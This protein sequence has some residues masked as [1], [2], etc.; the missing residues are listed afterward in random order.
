MRR[1]SALIFL[2]FLLLILVPA[3]TA[4]PKSYGTELPFVLGMGA[5][6][7]GMG[8]AYTSVL[9]DP[10]VQFFNPAS[11]SEA[12]WKQFEFFRTVLFDSK[13]VYHTLSYSHPTTSYGTLGIS[14]LRMDIGGIE[15]RDINNQL[16]SDDMKNSQTRVLLGY[17][18]R[19]HSTISAGLNLKIDYQSF[20]G[21]N[22][23]GLG[24]D[25][26]FLSMQKLNSI[27]YLKELREALA[28]QNL[29]EPSIKLDQESVPD[30]M[31]LVFG[32]SALSEYKD[33]TF[34]TSIDLVNP[35][36]SPFTFRFGQ[37]V[38]VLKHF[39]LRIGVDDVTPMYGF[40]V[41]YN[42]F[43]LDY[44]YRSEDLGSNHRVS[45]SIAFG[46]SIDEQ[47]ENERK[48]L[49]KRIEDEISMKMEKIEQE[50]LKNTFR[51][52]DS[53]FAI[54]IFEEAIGYYE[55]TL[56]S[57]PDNQSTLSRI[58]T[59][60]YQMNIKM[61]KNSI[62]KEDFLT[63]MV[64]LRQALIYMPDDSTSTSLIN[65]CEQKLSDLRDRTALIN[66]MLKNSIDKYAEKHYLEA[67]LGFEEI[68]NIDPSHT[69]AN[70]YKQKTLLTIENIKQQKITLA[71][72]LAEKKDYDG[73]IN[74]MEDA[75]YYAKD[76]P[77]IIAEI[78]SLKRKKQAEFTS[79]AKLDSG[80]RIPKQ[81]TP[82]KEVRVDKS[83]LD[84]LYR[85][86]MRHFESGN[87][88]DA[89]QAFQKL[90]TLDPQ[91]HHVSKLLTKA[92]LL[93]GMRLY[94][95][96]EYEEAVNIWEKSLK[97]DP[98]NLKAKRYLIKTREEMEKLGGVSNG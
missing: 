58:E 5:R 76:D 28:I 33:L 85:V 30:P 50:Q 19:L 90:W 21:V 92:Y 87:F 72:T 14:I 6:S 69:L 39:A 34:T 38:Q 41:S 62:Q 74:A 54:E 88:E 71:G 98:N 3:G 68:L 57:E 40:G 86:G 10:S 2:L 67:L 7:S 73:A 70:E 16:I 8:L 94:S 4:H 78:N 53:L 63:A 35:R 66:R 11:L 13:S 27:P 26:G 15:E 48:I 43:K 77:N 80:P 47:K 25:A 29:I 64:H 96:E 20:G 97:I 56:Q 59:A 89:T 18:R 22:G 75:L 84:E 1:R 24:F 79:V 23:S 93:M 46:S 9:G 65:M 17:A 44:A 60:K 12:K 81:S 95:N 61:G 82:V 32:I 91:Y 31:R 45:L 37:E 83:V 49:E 55:I 51:K 36:Y 42:A 52:A